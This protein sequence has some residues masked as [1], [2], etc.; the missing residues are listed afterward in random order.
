MQLLDLA[1]AVLGFR[2]ALA[3]DIGPTPEALAGAEGKALGEARGNEAFALN[4]VLRLESGYHPLASSTC[5][6]HDA[7]TPTRLGEDSH[8]LRLVRLDE[9]APCLWAART[10]DDVSLRS[11]LL[12]ETRVAFHRV[13]QVTIPP[14]HAAALAALKDRMPDKGQWA[15]L[16]PLTRCEEG[17]WRGAGLDGKGKAVIVTY[18][19]EGL[20]VG[21]GERGSDTSRK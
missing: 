16:L 20:E 3:E 19:P 2:L 15:T 7:R 4:N 11:C 12:S 13:A 18:G 9:S 8:T 14:E 5:W 6:S 17:P 21:A 10:P 1:L